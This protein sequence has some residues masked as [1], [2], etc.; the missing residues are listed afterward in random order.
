[1]QYKYIN[2]FDASYEGSA[3]SFASLPEMSGLAVPPPKLWLGND[4]TQQPTFPTEILGGNNC[5][6]V[7]SISLIIHLSF[8]FLI[9]VLAGA[10]QSLRDSF[11]TRTFY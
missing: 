5:S 8:S 11:F 6:S 10:A 7:A 3:G 4:S 9:V 2:T 1:M